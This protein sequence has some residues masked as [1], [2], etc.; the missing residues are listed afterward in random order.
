M[1]TLLPQLSKFEFTGVC[2]HTWLTLMLMAYYAVTLVV[3][4]A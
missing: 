4:A 2:H 3:E 1:V